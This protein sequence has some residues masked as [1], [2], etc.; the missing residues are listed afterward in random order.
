MTRVTVHDLDL[1]DISLGNLQRLRELRD[2]H[3][4]GRS[5]ICVELPRLMTGHTKA[6]STLLEMLDLRDGS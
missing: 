1:R 4:T 2:L 3:F 6:I 5:G